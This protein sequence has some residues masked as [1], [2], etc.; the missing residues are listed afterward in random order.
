MKVLLTCSVVALRTNLV[1]AW[2]TLKNVWHS[3]DQKLR[4][5]WWTMMHP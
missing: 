1:A 2:A 3:R 4:P 5:D